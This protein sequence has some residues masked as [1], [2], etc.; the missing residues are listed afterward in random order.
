MFPPREV[1]E[2]LLSVVGLY[3]IDSF[4]YF[5]QREMRRMLAI[6]YS[7]APRKMNSSFVCL[8]LSAFAFG[9]QW[10]HLDGRANEPVNKATDAAD[11]LAA[12]AQG[13][14]PGILIAPSSGAVSAC[15]ILSLYLLTTVSTDSAYSYM[16]IALR[17]GIAGNMHKE[18]SLSEFTPCQVESRHRLWW[19]IYSL[20]R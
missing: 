12:K 11:A 5:D 10:A 7:G 1:A 13:L 3:A 20:E 19:T 4:F 6:H 15:L 9:M 17:I 14:I 16:G 18:S 8:A 2:Y